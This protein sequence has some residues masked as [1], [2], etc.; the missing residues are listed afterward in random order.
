MTQ[1]P[2][3]GWTQVRSVLRVLATVLGVLAG[4]WLLYSLAGVIALLVLATFFAYML[5][6]AVV[7]VQRLPLW[8]SRGWA[9]IAAILIV[10]VSLFGSV[11]VAVYAVA[12]RFGSQMAELGH[13]G[14]GFV[15]AARGRVQLITR[16]YRAYQLP[17]GIQNAVES[18]A[19]AAIDLIGTTLR[20]GAATV[21]GWLRFL[22]WLI[23]IPVLAFF[24]LK[25]ADT[26]QRFALR[27]LPEG[28]TRWRGRDFIDEIN[29]TLAL[30][31]RAQLI[32]CVLIGGTC[33]IGFTALRVPYALVLGVL[34][35]LLEFIPLVGP[36]II[37]VLAGFL[38][39]T[40]SVSLMGFTL[41]FLA[42]LRFVQ[43][44][45][46][47]P[48]LVASGME[49]HPLAIIIT[50][51]CGSHLAGV[52]GLFLAIPAAAVLM[53]SHRYFLLQLGQANLLSA[54]VPGAAAEEEPAPLAPKQ[55]S[56]SGTFPEFRG[57][58]GIK[59]AVVDN[60]EDARGALV[61][62]LEQAGATVF[63]AGS[64]VEALV[65]LERNR[66][67]VLIS[68]LLMPDQDGYDLIRSVR[69]LPAEQGGQIRAAAL[70]GYATEEDRARTLAAG[71]QEHLCK[72]VE[73]SQLITT[74]I[75]LA[76]QTTGTGGTG[77]ALPAAATT[78]P[79]PGPVVAE[80]ES[81]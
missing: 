16:A 23:L 13:K 77:N 71:F 58:A 45:V 27:L 1:E 43:D 34:A 15:E 49:L 66:P 78:A 81:Q 5:S 72:P 24:F 22:P 26:F 35:G 2:S 76:S 3:V 42:V 18:G 79:G 11:T 9:R 68:D 75:T 52:A 6:P 48:R 21:L 63:A 40:Q 39:S 20:D 53:V 37:A 73:P 74:V 80:I 57:L 65:V 30:Y 51:L 29:R 61:D 54:L 60:D 56:R 69:D 59:V 55:P 41:L 47:Y 46:V 62:L 44:Y 33:W 32:A 25:D 28:R 14:P 38:A 7:L 70:S 10:Y 12:P 17:A 31:V 64:A 8:R 36:L 67:D 4:L 50:L 19:E